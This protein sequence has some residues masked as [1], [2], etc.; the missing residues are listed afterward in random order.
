MAVGSLSPSDKVKAVSQYRSFVTKLRV[1]S[2]PVYSDW[3]HLVASHY[4]LQC[5]PELFRLLKH[6][7]LCLALIVELPSPFI[8]PIP[9]LESDKDVFLSKSLQVSYQTVPHVSSLFRDPN[10]VERLSVCSGEGPTWYV[11]R[12]FLCAICS[13]EVVPVGQLCLEKWR[14]VTRKPFCV[15]ISLLCLPVPRLQV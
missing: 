14:L 9:N 7:C 2:V 12:N 5:R 8:V 1:G 6:S 13:R 10:A 3:I 4:E 11:T 15:M